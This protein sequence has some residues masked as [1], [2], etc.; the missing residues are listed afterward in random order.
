M[1]NTRILVVEDESIVALDIQARLR[2]LGYAAVG[3]ASSGE[4]AVSKAQQLQPDLVLMD[5]KLDGGMDGIEAASQIRSR[6]NIPVVYVTAYADEATLRRAQVTE[7]FGYILK[8]FDERE[9]YSTIEM[10]VYKHQADE[11]LRRSADLYRSLLDAS[12]ATVLRVGTQGKVTFFVTPDTGVAQQVREQALA[13]TL[14]DNI[15]PEDREKLQALVRE[16]FATGRPMLGVIF[17]TEIDGKRYHISSNFEPVKNAAGKVEEIQ[18]T[19]FDVTAQKRL[20]EQYHQAQKMESVG[21]LAGGV[22]HDFNNLLTAIMGYTEMA[23]AALPA[24]HPVRDYLE[25]VK[26]ASERAAGLTRQL[27]AFSRR[28][29]IQPRILDLGELVAN[30]ARMLKRIIGETVQLAVVGPPAV[31]PV[32][33]DL[34]QIEQVLV[35]LAVNA[36]DAMPQGGKLTIEIAN[37]TLDQAGAQTHN[38]LGSGDYVVVSVSDTG[39]GMTEEVKAHLFEPFFTTKPQGTGLGLATCFGIVK[40]SGGHISV[41]SEVGKGTTMR[42]Y[43][44][45]AAEAAPQRPDSSQPVAGARGTETVL[46]AEDEPA[47]RALATGVLRQLGYAVLEASNGAEALRVAGAHETVHIDLLLTDLVMPGMGGKELAQRLSAVRPSTKAL[48]MSGYAD[49]ALGHAGVLE[50]CTA[51]LQKPFDRATLAQKVREALDK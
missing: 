24:D 45:R 35:N 2:R 1:A 51:F 40:Q 14:G 48:F 33:T 32:K 39:A 18:I 30:L 9:L 6:F 8:P 50:P 43:L 21:R 31:W 47:V 12:G 27:L 7:P 3:A 44:P 36:R 5:I 4:E 37:V 23:L 16:T 34:G 42:G 25:E 11:A 17:R 41:Y 20:E 22:A 29:T 28:Q 19:A 38:G 10:A 13:G 15:V 49:G 46:V 26:G